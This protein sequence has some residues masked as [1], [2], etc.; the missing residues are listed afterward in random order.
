VG[1]TVRHDRLGGLQDHAHL[2]SP[3]L[4]QPRHARA[5]A[6]RSDLEHHDADA[7]PGRVGPDRDGRSVCSGGAA[8][9][10]LAASRS[11]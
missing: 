6:S 2:R 5:E 4:D 11:S 3:R 9:S 1:P 10:A 7:Y 8:A